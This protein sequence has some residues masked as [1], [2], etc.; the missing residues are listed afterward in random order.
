MGEASIDDRELFGRIAAGDDDA[1][2]VFYGLLGPA[3]RRAT[4]VDARGTRRASTPIRPGSGGAYLFVVTADTRPYERRDAAQRA[5]NDAFK[6]ATRAGLSAPEAMR[7][8][9]RAVG[10]RGLGATPTAPDGVLARFANG[11]TLR[12]AGPGRTSAPLPGVERRTGATP[13]T[14][15]A[16]LDV[17]RRGSGAT[18]TFTVRFRAPV[19]ITRADRHYTL[20]MDGPAAPSCRRRIPGGFDATTHDIARG[21]TVTFTVTP[22]FAGWNRRTWCP[23]AFTIYVG[24]QTPGTRSRGRL[25]G[26]YDFTV[27]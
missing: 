10:R 4:F 23:G 20:T 26:R 15:D 6:R 24:Y 5:L 12:V 11:A 1:F 17:R 18:A 9:Q 13:R 7:R 16:A 3:A 21:E 25:V 27:R 2:G 19:A 22:K 8:A 14:V